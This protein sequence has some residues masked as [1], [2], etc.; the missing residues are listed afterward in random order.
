M[1]VDGKA[2]RSGPGLFYRTLDDQTEGSA[3]AYAIEYWYLT[4][5][6]LT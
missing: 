6:L 5:S 3:M 1:G 2:K 4:A